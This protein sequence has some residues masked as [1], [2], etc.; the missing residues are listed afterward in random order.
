M[1]SKKQYSSVSHHYI[2]IRLPA[3][4]AELA[5]RAAA[6]KGAKL[7]TYLIDVIGSAAAT[8]LGLQA[9]SKHVE[10]G[11]VPPPPTLVDPALETLAETLAAR[12]VGA[13]VLLAAIARA[14]GELPSVAPH[15]TTGT[16][17]PPVPV[18]PKA[19]SGTYRLSRSMTP[20]ALTRALIEGNKK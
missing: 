11:S 1:P 19:P 6:S 17:R 4:H 15:G 13:D 20:A 5:A 16:L 7:S 3:E 9:P 8:D 12:G 18:P 2:S 14:V 10:T